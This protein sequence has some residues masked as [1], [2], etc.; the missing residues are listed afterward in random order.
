MRVPNFPMDSLMSWSPCH[1]L[2][3]RLDVIGSTPPT[4]RLPDHH[5]HRWVHATDSSSTRPSLPHRCTAKA[6]PPP[7]KVFFSA[8]PPSSSGPHCCLPDHLLCHRIHVALPPS[9]EVGSSNS[10]NSIPVSLCF[11]VCLYDYA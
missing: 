3:D 6:P 9:T 11:N 10:A 2:P 7:T 1:R 5:R 8:P 4:P